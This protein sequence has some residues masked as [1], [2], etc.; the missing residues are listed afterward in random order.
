MLSQDDFSYICRHAMKASEDSDSLPT[1][2]E[3]DNISYVGTNFKEAFRPHRDCKEFVVTTLC[4]VHYCPR[5]LHKFK[6][7]YVL[8]IFTVARTP[9][10]EEFYPPPDD[11]MQSTI[12][13][14]SNSNSMYL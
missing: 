1:D 5:Q 7:V 6:D 10:P 2:P 3:D 4:N 8:L 9:P 12:N 14:I 11:G 13:N